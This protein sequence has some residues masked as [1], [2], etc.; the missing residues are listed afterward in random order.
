MAGHKLLVIID[1]IQ[2]DSRRLE[3]ISLWNKLVSGC[4]RM[5]DST[6]SQRLGNGRIEASNQGIRQSMPSVLD[7]YVGCNECM[8]EISVQHAFEI[9]YASWPNQ[10]WIAFRCE[11]CGCSNPLL[12]CNDSLT[13]GYLSGA[14]APYLIP[15]RRVSV[16]GLR[17]RSE[18]TSAF[19]PPSGRVA[20]RAPASFRGEGS[21]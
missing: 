4:L 17:T 10:S 2:H 11:T 16:P 5:P 6:K 13:E 14:P 8:A 3:R 12:V 18:I 20:K 1:V 15:K 7:Q 21:L 9:A 19:H